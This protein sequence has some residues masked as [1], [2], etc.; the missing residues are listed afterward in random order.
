MNSFAWIILHPYQ[1]SQI[2]DALLQIDESYTIPLTHSE[3]QMLANVLIQHRS[4]YNFVVAIVFWY[5]VLKHVNVASKFL[6]H[7]DC[8]LSITIEII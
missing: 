8:D 1:I 7:R 4:G 2:Y 6:Q 3:A 5:E